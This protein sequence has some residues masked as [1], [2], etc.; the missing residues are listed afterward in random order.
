MR[1]GKTMI[2]TTNNITLTRGLMQCLIVAI[3]LILSATAMAADTANN[4][5][6]DIQDR[7]SLQA[8][9]VSLSQIK[10]ELEEKGIGSHRINELIEEGFLYLSQGENNLATEAIRKVNELK[11]LAE[12]TRQKIIAAQQDHAFLRSQEEEQQAEGVLTEGVLIGSN[13]QELKDI[14]IGIV[15]AQ[16]EFDHEN[17]EGAN[18]EIERV[19]KKIMQAGE[20]AYGSLKDRISQ[21]TNIAKESGVREEEI[22]GLEKKI[23]SALESGTISELESLN[24]TLGKAEEAIDSYLELGKVR[25]DLDRIGIPT[26]RLTDEMTLARI[27]IESAS[28]ESAHNRAS[29]ARELGQKA[30]MLESKLSNLSRTIE[31][32]SSNM[33]TAAFCKDVC[34]KET[35]ESIDNAK[36]ELMLGN[37]ERAEIEALQ[38]EK[39]L[40]ETRADIAVQHIRSTSAGA[41]IATL[42]RDNWIILLVVAIIIMILAAA[43]KD[44][45]TSR[46]RLYRLD[47]ARRDLN[48]HQR[49]VQEL[50]KDYYIRRRMSRASYNSSYEELEERILRT[51]E[52]IARVEKEMA[53]KDSS[54]ATSKT[55]TKNSRNIN[56]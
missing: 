45:I 50:Q 41:R 48:T 32:E 56:K 52:T 39:R 53:L 12:K 18:Q 35:K 27:E 19:R 30:V 34:F 1:T 38:A 15:T 24:Q 16:S 47:K 17:F 28:Y 8:Q 20:D 7:K 42:I 26:E 11:V 3:I 40:E 54:T 9:L 25:E 46:I 37:Y 33:E 29:M 21:V 10:G 22:A 13:D 55:K 23:K 4:P 43:G 6:D 31:D 5:G 49:M 2:K 14:E 51:D 36:Q 44:T